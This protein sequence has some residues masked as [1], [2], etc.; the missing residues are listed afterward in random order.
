[1]LELVYFFRIMLAHIFDCD[2]DN[3]NNINAEIYSAKYNNFFVSAL[4]R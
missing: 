3:S 1:V 2:C 4:M